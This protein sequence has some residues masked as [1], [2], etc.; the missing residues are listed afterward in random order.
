MQIPRLQHAK[1]ARG[2]LVVDKRRLWLEI[3]D[4]YKIYEYAELVGK[5]R[6][7]CYRIFKDPTHDISIDDIN[8]A[9]ELLEMSPSEFVAIEQK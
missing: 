5:S 8:K 2:K 9:A 1:R 4:K 7:T 3:R 6:P